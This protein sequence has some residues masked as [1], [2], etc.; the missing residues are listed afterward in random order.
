[1]LGKVKHH[2]LSVAN[3]IERIA[4]LSPCGSAR[5]KDD[6]DHILKFPGAAPRQ[7]ASFGVVLGQL[8]C[9]F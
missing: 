4:N 2:V 5:F 6:L 9:L 8:S 7:V 1:M 3:L